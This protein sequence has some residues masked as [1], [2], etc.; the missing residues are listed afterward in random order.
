MATNLLIGTAQYTVDATSITSSSTVDTS[1]PI[2]NI[3]T[4]PRGTY[5]QLAAANT[6]WTIDFN[7]SGS[8][9]IVIDYLFV[10]RANLLKAAGATRLKL[11]GYNGAYVNL[12]GTDAGLA[13]KT[14]YGPRSEDAIFTSDLANSDYTIPSTANYTA[15]RFHPCGAAD[16][17]KKY[18]H[19]KMYCGTWFDPGHDPVAPHKITKITRQPGDRESVYQFTFTWQGITD[20]KRNEFFTNLF[21]ERQKP[22]FLYTR[23]YHDVLLEHR[24]VHCFV[25]DYSTSYISTNSHE[26]TIIFEEM[27]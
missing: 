8:T 20:T 27:I 18:K 6:V 5:S 23:T 26:I 21:N 1:Y 15:L 25:A 24:V 4:G 16:P 22:V 19:S 11:Q 2:E 10:A 12:A 9:S 14:L 17:S 13:S 3:I 7:L